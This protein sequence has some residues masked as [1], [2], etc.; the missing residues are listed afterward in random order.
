[1]EPLRILIADDDSLHVMSLRRQLE[2]LGHRIVAEAYT[3]REAVL[4]AAAQQPDL[5][6]LDI[7]MPDMDGIEAARRITAQRP[8]P[9]LL[10]SA[11]SEQ[12]LAERADQAGVFAYLVKPVTARDLRPAL[13]LAR[14]RFHEFQLLRQ[15]VDD[16]RQA[17]ETR[18]LV[19][20]AKGILMRRLGL[21]EEEAF[22]RLQKRSQDENRK[23]REVAQAIITADEM[24]AD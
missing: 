14:S 4:L 24:F 8:I 10:I 1:M 20:R 15:E 21:G 5:A 3:G 13:F 16:L 17:L 18:K 22:R 2:E 12:T 23:M 9:I 7:M 11:H 6:L 19:E